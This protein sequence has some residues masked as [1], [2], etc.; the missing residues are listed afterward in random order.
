MSINYSNKLEAR[1]LLQG[2]STVVCMFLRTR[3]VE[4]LQKLPV[5]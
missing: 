3:K 1:D 4:I 2:V 5:K